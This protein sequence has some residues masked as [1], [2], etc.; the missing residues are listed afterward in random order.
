MLENDPWLRYNCARRPTMSD[1]PV[2]VKFDFIK[3]SL[4][5]V[6]HADGIFGG[7]TPKGDIFMS[8]FSERFPIPT[9]VVHELKPSGELGPEVRSER[10]GRKG[11]LREVEVGV[12]CD[13]EV[14]KAVHKWLAEKIADAEKVRL[15][16]ASGELK[17]NK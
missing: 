6:V 4:F 11:L 15:S 5:R 16:Q 3:S 7:M 14:A 8:F 1:S 9:S 10:E 13:L 2:T 12:Y 17:E